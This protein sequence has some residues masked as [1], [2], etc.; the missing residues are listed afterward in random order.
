MGLPP[1]FV[2]N[3]E[4]TLP[5]PITWF[6]VLFR[7]TNFV[8]LTKIFL[9]THVLRCGA[10]FSGAVYYPT[11]ALC[12]RC[13]SVKSNNVWYNSCLHSHSQKTNRHPINA[14]SRNRNNF[15]QHD[16]IDMIPLLI[17]CA[18][19]NQN[20]GAFTV[21]VHFTFETTPSFRKKIKLDTKPNK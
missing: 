21:Y 14:P 11:N 7:L 8:K 17:C 2:C 19:P 16:V 6:G 1:A 13:V 20:N 4:S 10:G 9:T 18:Q 15:W 5:M 12:V 3:S